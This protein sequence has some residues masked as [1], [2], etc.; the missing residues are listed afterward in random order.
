MFAFIASSLH[1]D[2]Y[3]G[4][5]RG[6]HTLTVVSKELLCITGSLKTIYGSGFN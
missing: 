6:H 5:K 4:V 3:E 1:V 2:C